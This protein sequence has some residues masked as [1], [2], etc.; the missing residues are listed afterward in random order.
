MEHGPCLTKLC[1]DDVA[2]NSVT[3]T[4]LTKLEGGR[5]VKVCPAWLT[6]I[7]TVSSDW[8]TRLGTSALA[9]ALRTICSVRLAVTI[10]RHIK[11]ESSTSSTKE[12]IT[13]KLG[14]ENVTD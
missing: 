6:A 10:Y 14:L 8:I 9:A 11:K 2:C 7:R 5:L 3:L 13:K 4:S 12:H 1:V